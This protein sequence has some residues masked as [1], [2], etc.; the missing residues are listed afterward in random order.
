VRA[1]LRVSRII[2]AVT[3]SIG[4]LTIWLVVIMVLIGV[5]NVVGRVLTR[6]AGRNLTSNALI[7][8]QWYMFSLVFFLGAAYTLLHNGHVRVDV[9]YARWAPRR[10]AVIDLLGSLLF[11]IPFSALVIYFSYRS[12]MF[13]WMIREG[14]P[15]AGGL[16]RY[17]IK[18]LVLV[19][20]GLLILQGCSETIKN[21]AVLAGVM[22]PKEEH[23]DLEL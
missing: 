3:E 1:L 4:R 17:P 19:S 11:L 20:F 23:S 13:S 9:L 6:Y 18:T 7:E 14:S 5:W 16:P 15:D 12:V 21:A 22:Q 8:I 10:R 2:D